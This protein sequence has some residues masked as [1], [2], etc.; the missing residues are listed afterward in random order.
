LQAYFNSRDVPYRALA[1]CNHASVSER[2][3]FF[4]ADPDV[5]SPFGSAAAASAGE[6]RVWAADQA[7][8]WPRALEVHYDAYM[9]L[10]DNEIQRIW[11][12]LVSLQNDAC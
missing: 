10:L 4:L 9:S 3:P 2:L 8:S 11:V 6:F 7:D 12:G 5:A 1:S